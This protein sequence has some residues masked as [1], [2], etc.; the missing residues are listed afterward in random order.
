M[1]IYYTDGF[2]DADMGAM[3]KQPNSSYYMNVYEYRASTLCLCMLPCKLDAMS[4]GF[5]GEANASPYQPII[6]TMSTKCG[7]P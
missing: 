4:G 2:D 7:R 5:R 6:F 3:F 1:F